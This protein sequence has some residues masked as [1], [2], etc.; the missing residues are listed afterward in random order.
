M[1]EEQK[2]TIAWVSLLIDPE[3]PN[4]E[5]SLDSRCNKAIEVLH[6]MLD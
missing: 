2:A 3:N 5:E 6:K 1:T 4:T